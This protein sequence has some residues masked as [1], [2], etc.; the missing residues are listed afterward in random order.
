[1]PLNSTK[2]L[3]GELDLP[4]WLL[5]LCNE[6]CI[7][8]AV[9]RG[10]ENISVVQG[11]CEIRV[12]QNV[13]K[14][15]P[16]LRIET[17]RDPFDVV[18]LEQGKIEVHQSGSDEC[19]PPQVPAEC[20][21]IGDREALRL[22]V[23]DGITWVHQR[24]APW[25]GNQVRNIDVWICAFHSKRVSPKTRSER[26]SRAS[27]EHS[28]YLPSSQHPRFVSGRPLRRADFP[29]VIDL[30]VLGDVKIRES[31]IQSRIE[32]QRTGD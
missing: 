11:R 15:G 30:Q 27:F 2:Q 4:R 20:D 6:Y 13:E 8:Y 31:A 28:S 23:T 19:V 3:N 22:D 17:I 1:M 10:I 26:H 9:P 12:V 29:R 25:T 5:G 24:T 7:S 32:P 14:L 16:K 18:V 21:G